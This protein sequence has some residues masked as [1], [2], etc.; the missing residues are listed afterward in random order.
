MFT[1]SEAIPLLYEHHL[2]FYVKE[3]F[4]KPCFCTNEVYLEKS[5]VI[6]M[7]EVNRGNVRA[8]NVNLGLIKR[9]EYHFLR[10]L[11]DKGKQR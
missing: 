9:K 4:R 6:R 11:I 8:L 7:D 5:D 3:L 2:N 1:V 10:K